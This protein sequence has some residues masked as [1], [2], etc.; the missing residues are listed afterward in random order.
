MKWFSP[1][2][3]LCLSFLWVPQADAQ[4]AKRYKAKALVKKGN[5][6]Y[7]IGELE[8]ALAHFKKALELVN[9]P[10]IVFNIAQCHRQLEKRKEAIFFYKL[11]LD[12]WANANPTDT[13]PLQKEVA[14]HVKKLKADLEREKAEQAATMPSSAGSE[15]QPV[16]PIAKQIKQSTPKPSPSETPIYK[17]WW[18]WTVIGVAVAGATAGTIAGVM[19]QPDGVVAGTMPG[20]H[21]GIV[22]VSP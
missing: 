18:F 16:H 11:Y 14:E 3:F 17:K 10:T 22:H 8:E 6:K 5:V 4:R 9:N 7:R 2:A 13:N 12:E 20:E 19:L 1:V 21:G 15:T